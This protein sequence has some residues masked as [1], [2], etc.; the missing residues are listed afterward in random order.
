M[1]DTP[2]SAAADLEEITDDVAPEVVLDELEATEAGAE[3]H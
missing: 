1:L 2:I 3:Q